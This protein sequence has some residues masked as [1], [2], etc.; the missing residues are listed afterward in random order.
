MQKKKSEAGIQRQRRG[1]F[2]PA[3]GFRLPDFEFRILDWILLRE[4][5][6]MS[7]RF[8]AFLPHDRG[9]VLEWSNRAAC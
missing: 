5:D 6:T 2:L 7:S 3:P 1:F 4:L 9:E 8:A